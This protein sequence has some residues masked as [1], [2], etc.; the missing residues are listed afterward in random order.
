MLVR[1]MSGRLR[2]L[3]GMDS[4]GAGRRLLTWRAYGLNGD[5]SDHETAAKLGS[6]LMLGSRNCGEF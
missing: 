1:T 5:V 2:T 6:A 4:G 3:A